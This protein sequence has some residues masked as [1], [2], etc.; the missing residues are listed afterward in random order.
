LRDPLSYTQRIAQTHVS[1]LHPAVTRPGRCVAEIEV[2]RLSP[3][4]VGQY[5]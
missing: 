4:A 3:A 2:G 1:R 5:L